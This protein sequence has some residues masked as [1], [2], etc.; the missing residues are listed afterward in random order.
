[1]IEEEAMLRSELLSLLSRMR[2]DEIVV[3]TMSAFLDWPRYSSHPWDLMDGDTMGQAAPV[4]LGLALA[5]PDRPVWVL[6]GDGSQLM[7]LGSLVTIGG[8]APPNLYIFV[9]R[10]NCYEITGGQPVPGAHSL[11]LTT[12]AQGC[13][14]AQALRL[15]TIAELERGL[16]SILA[17]PG[18]ALL[19]VSIEGP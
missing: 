14:F 12:I 13:G 15:E 3:T 19:D 11:Q 4:G 1:M 2:Q 18:P 8:L 6:N 9:L 5:R 10:N 17:A 16:P 7:S